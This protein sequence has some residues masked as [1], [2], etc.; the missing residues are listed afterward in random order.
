MMTPGEK[1][2]VPMPLDA[3]ADR[4]LSRAR[5]HSAAFR[6]TRTLSGVSGLARVS[7]IVV[8]SVAQAL[9]ARIASLAVPDAEGQQLSIV[10]TH[11][12]PLALVEHLRIASGEGVL[13]GVYQSRRSLCVQDVSTVPGIL[14]RPR[15]A[16]SSFMA[17]PL[18]AGPDVLGVIAVSDRTDGEP[19]SRQDLSLLRAVAAP[20]ALALARERAQARAESFAHAAAIDPVSGLFNRR[21][22]DVRVEEEL[23][24]AGRDNVQ[25]ALLMIDI[26]D[27]KAVNDTYGHPVGDLVIKDTSEILRRAVRTFDICARAGLGDE[28]AIVM[29]SS[30][31]QAAATV[32]ERIRQRIERYRPAG[33]ESLRMTASVG[34]AMSAPDQTARDLTARADEALYLAKRAGKNQVRAIGDDL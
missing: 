29:P 10:A 12:Y 17:V 24:R 7:E 34:I 8:R 11:G 30:T 28:F 22:F 23:Q 19:F 20:A 2:D 13:G 3:R 26:D 4:Q 27:F 32:A 21:Y 18:R 5:A 14:R 1:G 25:V 31:L 16:T 9:R 33:V 6:L 15:Y